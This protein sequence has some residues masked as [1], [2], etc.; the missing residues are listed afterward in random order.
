MASSSARSRAIWRSSTS[1]CERTEMYSPA[2]IEKAPASRPAIPE[3]RMIDGSAVAPATPMMSERLLTRPSDAPK[4][5]ARSVPAPPRCQFS[6]FVIS[7]TLAATRPRRSASTAVDGAASAT[8]SLLA[9]LAPHLGVPALVGGHRRRRVERT[10][11]LRPAAPRGRSGAP[12][13]PPSRA[14]GRRRPGC[15]AARRRRGRSGP[16]GPGRPAVERRSR[17]RGGAAPR[18]PRGAAR[19]PRWCA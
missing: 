7:A 19:R 6:A 14:R 4:T 5:I 10:A 3:R 1:T 8:W 15:R 12:R 2:A 16:A 9:D 18:W 13:R 17:R 11:R